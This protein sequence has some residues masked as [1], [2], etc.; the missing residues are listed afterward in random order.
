MFQHDRF[1]PDPAQAGANRAQYTLPLLL[2][3]VCYHQPNSQAFQQWVGGKWHALSH[4]AFQLASEESALGLLGLKLKRGDRIS[5]W[6]H[7]D[8]NFC[9]ADMACLLAGLV[10]VPIDI[11]FPLETVQ[12]ILQQTESRAIICSDL[13]LLHRL[14]PCLWHTDSVQIIILTAELPDDLE[15][16]P[17]LPPQ[18]QVLSMSQLQAKGRLHW[19]EVIRQEL[20]VAIRPDDSATIVYTAAPDGQPRGVMLSHA[21]LAGNIL[22]AFATF[23]TLKRGAT[24]VALLFLPLT[25]IFA[26]TFFYGHLEYGH[27]IFFTTPSRVT[28]HLRSVQPTI[29]ITVP[30]L[31]EKTYEK[32]LET[33]NQLVGFRRLVFQWGL[34]LAQR[35]DVGHSP[36]G[37]YALQLRLAN[38]LIF[39]HWRAAFGGRVKY[40]ICGGAALSGDLVN[41]FTAAGI[42]VFQGYGLTE[43]SSVLCCNRESINQ[44][45]TVGLPIAGVEIQIGE[46]GEI[47][48]KTPYCMQG[49]F[50]DPE[51][52]QTA[53]DAEGWLHTGDLGEFTPEGLLK[54]TGY[55]KHLFKLSTGKYIAPQPIEQALKQSPLVKQAIVVGAQHKFCALLIF[56]DLEYL[57][58]QAEGMCFELAVDTLLK[59][60]KIT[61]QYQTLVDAINPQLPHWSTIKRFRLLHLTL[62]HE[63]GQPAPALTFS[64]DQIDRLFASEIEEMYQEEAIRNSQ[65]AA[66]GVPL[67]VSRNTP[68]ATSNAA[69]IQSRGWLSPVM[70]LR[71]RILHPLTRL[72]RLQ[73]GGS[74]DHG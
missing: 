53:I 72:T 26:R 43:S 8:I 48:A 55:K 16:R 2:D 58:P 19:S 7:S 52:T 73:T 17:Q 39:P 59:H 12:F 66:S 67:R 13:E 4:Q 40:L 24:E 27:Q 49:Y 23:P 10:N 31:L 62:T 29:F 74:P 46:D 68:Q 61:A 33:G 30:R 65:E 18:I 28:K 42:P 37:L 11:G 36:R 9:I 3:Q 35:Y 20:Y 22:A 60:P 34:G 56:P 57:C 41:W 64:R 69:R 70:T 54:I 14:A 5:L 21:S 15:K 25:H 45:G 32:I 50:K 51:A 6:M 47:L 1:D 38:R 63:A 44:A 71:T